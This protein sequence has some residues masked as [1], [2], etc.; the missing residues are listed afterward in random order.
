MGCLDEQDC[1]IVALLHFEAAHYG[2][3][4]ADIECHNVAALPHRNKPAHSKPREGQENNGANQNDV[5]GLPRTQRRHLGAK[6]SF[7]SPVICK[8]GRSFGAAM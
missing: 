8:L 7:V 1:Q 4:D 2:S 3:P 6:F 5:L